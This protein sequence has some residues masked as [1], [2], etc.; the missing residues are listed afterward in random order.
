MGSAP[1][2]ATIILPPLVWRDLR[3]ERGI[4]WF[5]S[6]REVQ[7]APSAETGQVF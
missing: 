2:G 4:Q 7:F 5:D 1:I 3:F 6:T